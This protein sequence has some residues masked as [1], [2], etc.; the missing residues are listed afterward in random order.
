MAGSAAAERWP[1]ATYYTVVARPGDSIASLGA[2]YHVSAT[3][4]ARLNRIGIGHEIHP[5]QVLRIPAATRTTRQAVLSEALDSRLP[6]YAS[7]PRPIASEH[8]VSAS[9]RPTVSAREIAPPITERYTRAANEPRA[10]GAKPRFVWP[11]AGSVIS[12]FGLHGEGERND[13]INISAELG[14][15]I[16]AAAA[17]I[18][19]YAGDG[20]KNY[21]NL[22]LIT[23][24]DGYVTAYAHTDSISVA[25]GDR[26]EQGQVIGTAGE[27]GGVD[28]PQLHFEIRHDVKPV[29]PG[30]LL[31]ASR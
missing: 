13:G 8:I 18:V 2:R 4:I 23:H 21:G 15:P 24:A 11:I 26:V 10:T 14:Q 28:R 9:P 19:T 22:I 1:D 25:R 17:G 16:H 3:Q 27:T 6:N 31:V 12:R 5:G 29:D 7:P 30:T 20:L